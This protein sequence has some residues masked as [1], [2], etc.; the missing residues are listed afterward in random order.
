[1]MGWRFV[2]TDAL[3]EGRQ[4]DSVK[5]IFEKEGERGFR[6]LEQEVIFSLKG[7]EGHVIALGGGSLVDPKN[8]EFLQS[9][10]LVVYLK[11]NPLVLLER[12]VPC[13]VKGEGDFQKLVRE[14]IA[15]YEEVADL[16]VDV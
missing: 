8:C 15:G 2:D 7:V 9:L 4:G 3:M 13:F 16:I 1:M 11:A 12:G 14:R 10:G 5:G 6:Q